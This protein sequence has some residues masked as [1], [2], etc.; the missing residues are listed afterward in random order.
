MGSSGCL[1]W[2]ACEASGSLNFPSLIRAQG[3]GRPFGKNGWSAQSQAIGRRMNCRNP[4]RTVGL[5]MVVSSFEVHAAHD[6]LRARQR[7]MCVLPKGGRATHARAETF[8]IPGD[9]L[10]ETRFAEVVSD[11]GPETTM[12]S[13]LRLRAATSRQPRTTD[14]C[15]GISNPGAGL[16]R[17]QTIHSQTLGTLGQRRE[18]GT[19][20]EIRAGDGGLCGNSFGARLARHRTRGQGAGSRRALQTK[21]LPLTYRG[22]Q[23]DHRRALERSAILWIA[24]QAR[25]GG[26][27]WLE[28]TA[29][30][31][32]ARSILANLL[33]KGSNR[34]SIRSTLSA[35]PAKRTSRVRPAKAGD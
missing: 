3:R 6:W 8:Q 11:Q 19:T 5:T 12:A 7:A 22:C 29:L 15:G 1:L 26:E 9:D 18:R 4:G 32:G 13:A 25:A 27:S 14:P 31:N 2:S 10:A 17:T 16:W 21:A 28:V 24:Q 30:P 34:I 33:R 35:K 23:T 20:A